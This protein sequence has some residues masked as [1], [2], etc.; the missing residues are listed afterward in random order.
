[1]SHELVVE[2]HSLTKRY[3][4]VEAVRDLSLTVERERITGFLGRN[5]AGKST[6]I[7]MLLGMIRPTSGTGRVLGYDIADPAQSVEIRRRIAYVG[8]DKGLYGYMTVADLIRFTRSFYPDWQPDIEASLIREYQL[9]LG[10][11]VKAI[12]KG[13]RTKLALL[14]ALARRPELII[15]DEPTEGLD[16]VSIEELLQTLQ[17][18]RAAGTSIFFS[19][20]HLSEVEQIADRVLMIDKGQLVMD[21]LLSDLLNN[22][23][24]ITLE[25]STQSAMPAFDLVGIERTR[26][27]GRQAW[28]LASSNVEGIVAHARSLDAVVQVT[29]VNL[30]D[31]FLDIVREAS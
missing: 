5:G 29:P 22:Y 26:V 10:R 14:L 12:S 17:E 9:P 16:P 8:E 18:V 19:S 31:V 30:R 3:G 27:K 20:H 7:K 6:T 13:M 23:C 1:M 11:K 21:T 28:V 15:L 25:F 24:N 4:T 2:T